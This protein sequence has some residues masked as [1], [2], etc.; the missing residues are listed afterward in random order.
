MNFDSYL[1]GEPGFHWFALCLALFAAVAAVDFSTELNVSILYLAPVFIAAWIFGG[2]VPVMVGF[3][4]AAFL[5]LFVFVVVTSTGYGEGRIYH[6][7]D[8]VIQFVT[9]V[10]FAVIIARLKAALSHAD[11]RFATVL[12]GLDVPVYVSDASTGKLLYVNGPFRL[13]FTDGA[14]PPVLPEGHR[15]G[16]VREPGTGR[17]F[18][19]HVQP[20]H[21]IDGRMT[22]LHVATDITAQRRNEEIFLQQQ[23]KLS[24][25][26]RLV[27]VG[28][29][30]TTLAHE[31]NQPL[32]AIANYNMG[33]VRRLRS[34]EWNTAELL[35]AMEKGAAQAER[36][37]SV[38]QRLREFL[39]RRQPQL[40]ACDINEVVEELRPTI[41]VEAAQRSVRLSLALSW[42]IPYARADRTLMEQVILNLARNAID[43]MEDT[44]AAER[45]LRIGSGIGADNT[46]EVTVADRGKGIAP[47]LEADLF[48]PFFSSKPEGM[49]LGLH[50]SRSIVEA[51]GG[52]I[53]ATPNTGRGTVF[54]FS[55][56]SVYA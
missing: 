25:T 33:C 16:E 53:W 22:R 50:I 20:L 24:L 9:W 14:A 18:L 31:L 41:E 45:E 55:L 15:Q 19:V 46:I 4:G 27:A 29:M 52:H 35:E 10:L 26:A 42:R 51:H 30:A 44:P 21:W 43:A 28:E 32:A 7:W 40:A 37:S 54:R 39:A 6:A 56:Q 11:E 17:W 8:A 49:G 1:R 5:L 38:I 23:E 36:A 48:R 2:N 3:F 47:E 34:G 12:E 13:T